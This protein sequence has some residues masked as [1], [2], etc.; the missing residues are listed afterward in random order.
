MNKE[1]PMNSSATCENSNGHVPDGGFDAVLS[2]I[3][4]ALGVR[5][6]V[7]LGVRL[8]IRQPTISDARRRDS[9]PDSWLV[10]LV[11]DHSL[12]PVWVLR[13]SGAKYLVPLDEDPQGSHSSQES[14]SSQG[15]DFENVLRNAPASVLLR[16]LAVRMNRPDIRI[17]EGALAPREAEQAEV[18]SAQRVV[19]GGALAPRE[20]TLSEV[21][22]ARRVVA[23][24]AA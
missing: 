6:Q 19:A 10:R 15:P 20:A 16:V 2:R 7:E 14:H 4:N 1:N 22:S 9:V 8:G 13:G 12:N 18:S 5:T 21:S 17:M 11:A 3:M 24:G 23:G